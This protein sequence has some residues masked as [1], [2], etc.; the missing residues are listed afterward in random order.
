MQNSILD[1]VTSITWGWLI[2]I[3]ERRLVP[4]CRWVVN[5]KKAST[6]FEVKKI[7]GIPH[8]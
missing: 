6:W 2:V 7:L 4:V 3:R 5:V 1:V 8:S